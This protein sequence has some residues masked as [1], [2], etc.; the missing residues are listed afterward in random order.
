MAL[1]MAHI[2][3]LLQPAHTKKLFKPSFVKGQAAAAS[4]KGQFLGNT[5]K[6]SIGLWLSAHFFPSRAKFVLSFS[7]NTAQKKAPILFQTK[8]QNNKICKELHS[9]SATKRSQ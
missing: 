5:I 1:K 3:Y 2:T 4:R 8:L 7:Y 9:T 6:V